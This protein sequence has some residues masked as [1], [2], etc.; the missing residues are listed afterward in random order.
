M[1]KESKPRDLWSHVFSAGHDRPPDWCKSCGYYPVINNGE[2]HDDC[3]LVC[4]PVCDCGEHLI[5]AES[6]AAGRCL[7]CRLFGAS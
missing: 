4:G 2:H 1:S 6:L 7:E 3:F 5:C